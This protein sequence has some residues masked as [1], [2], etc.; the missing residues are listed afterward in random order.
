MP[1]ND[2]V[3]TGFDDAD[4]GVPSRLPPRQL[5]VRAPLVTDAAG[6]GMTHHAIMTRLYRD[7]DADFPASEEELV[8]IWHSK[9]SDPRHHKIAVATLARRVVGMAL[10]EPTGADDRG[11]GKPAREREIVFLAMLEEFYDQ[12]VLQRMLDFVL[13]DA[14]PAQ[15]WVLRNDQRMRRFLRVNGFTLDGLSAV[16]S[17]NVEYS[18]LVR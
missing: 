17:I 12:G 13:P 2:I 11:F 1:D 16:D 6:A 3:A 10:V 15:I 7:H 4:L 14:T 5:T 9:I 8:D 18:R